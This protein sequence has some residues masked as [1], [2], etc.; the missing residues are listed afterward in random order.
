MHEK[1]SSK[2]FHSLINARF[3]PLNKS[4]PIKKK[5]LTIILEILNPIPEGVHHTSSFQ[6]TFP[7]AYRSSNNFFC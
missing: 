1:S 6:A 2:F 3:L 7:F 5:P 4:L